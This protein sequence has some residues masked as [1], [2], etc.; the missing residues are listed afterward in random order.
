MKVWTEKSR[1]RRVSFVWNELSRHLVVSITA[2]YL[3]DHHL[4]VVG[5]ILSGAAP[6]SCVSGSGLYKCQFRDSSFELFVR[7]CEPHGSDRWLFYLDHER[8]R[9]RYPPGLSN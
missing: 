6:E 1:D 2:M 4:F 5:D 7:Y 9:S 3:S 8:N